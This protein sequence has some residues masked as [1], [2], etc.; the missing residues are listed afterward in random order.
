[1][2]S[3]QPLH[4]CGAATPTRRCSV[5]ISVRMIGFA[6]NQKLINQRNEKRRQRRRLYKSS[7]LNSLKSVKKF[8]F[9]WAESNLF[10]VEK[11]TEQ[12]LISNRTE[13]EWKIAQKKVSF[14]S[15]QRPNHILKSPQSTDPRGAKWAESTGSF[16]LIQAESKVWPVRHE[17]LKKPLPRGRKKAPNFNQQ[18]GSAV[19][20]DDNGR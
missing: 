2:R 1:M 3:P 8:N 9:K 16:P 19:E 18:M 12:T 10:L 17:S 15:I 20:L 5:L 7:S 14:P 13:S 6:A 11:K 4:S